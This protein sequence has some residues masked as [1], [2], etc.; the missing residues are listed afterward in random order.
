MRFWRC[1][2]EAALTCKRALGSY[3]PDLGVGNP[4]PAIGIVLSREARN[5]SLRPQDRRGID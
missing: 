5:R 4:C 3:L 1:I 2:V